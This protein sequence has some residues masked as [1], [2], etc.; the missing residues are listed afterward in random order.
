MIIKVLECLPDGTQE[1]VDREVADDYFD[2]PP[3][4]EAEP[5]EEQKA[6]TELQEA[7]DAL[8]EGLI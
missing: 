6:I 7:F 2:F 1:L 8:T 3:V 5:T 4:P